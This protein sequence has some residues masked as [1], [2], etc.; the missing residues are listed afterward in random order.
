MKPMAKGK[1][2]ALFSS[3]LARSAGAVMLGAASFT[4]AA[5]AH[6]TA[7][8]DLEIFQNQQTLLCMDDS[9]GY[10]MRA[11]TCNGGDFQ[12]W[13]VHVWGD[14]TRQL[15]NKHTGRCLSGN[16][17]TPLAAACYASEAQSWFI[18]HWADGT[19]R[20]R[21]QSTETCI[22]D[23]KENGFRTHACNDGTAHSW[24]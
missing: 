7:A 17:S 12:Q 10:G 6:A 4:I 15:K 19:I 18:D 24:F 16:S 2:A 11:Y 20:F 14:S 23:S 8:D 21:N 5:A 9:T 13:Y 22:D 3:R 1:A